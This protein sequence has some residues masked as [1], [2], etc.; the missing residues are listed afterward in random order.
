MI[1]VN[2]LWR[3]LSIRI[4]FLTSFFIV[5]ALVS[6]FNIYL[7]NNNYT[8]TDQFN[9]TMAN[10]YIINN[11]QVLVEDNRQSV[12]NYLRT[13]ED[14]EKNRYYD[15][16]AEIKQI[17]APL[18]NQ[19]D[20]LDIY[21][22]IKAIINSTN[23]YF[24]YFDQAIV[25]RESKKELYYVSYYAGSDIQK[26]TYSYIQELLYLSLSEGAKL[27]NELIEEIEVMRSV[28]FMLNI[29]AFIFAMFIGL[30]F[31][32]YLINPIKRLAEKSM[33][34]ANGDLNVELLPA[35]SKDEIGV[36]ANSFNI[37]SASI[38]KY[39]KDLEKKV[40][41]EKKLHI[42]EMEVIRMEQLVKEARFEAL[43]SQI[44][45]HFLFNTL[46]TISR[47][48]FFEDAQKTVKLIQSLSTL[49]RVR[50][51]H[52]QNFVSITEELNMIE[53]YIYLQKVRFGDRL[54]YIEKVSDNCKNIKVP[55]F[56]F[57]PIIENAIIH[58]VE[59]KVEGGTVRVKIYSKINQMGKEIIIIRITDT[60]I[61]MTRERINEIKEFKIENKKSIGVS[62]VYHRFMSVTKQKGRFTMRSHMGKGTFIEFRFEKGVIND[63]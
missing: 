41:I 3:H 33:R 24:D 61:G 46:N 40:E 19:Y 37:M 34:M 54:T 38:R 55:V 9:K 59:A 50:L 63:A 39:V 17:I 15:T 43:Q 25:D 2:E 6:L 62:N 57:Q 1:K 18:Y 52:N 36:L 44:N 7:N 42:E 32:N 60:G 26:Y 35:Q 23:S 29:G 53:E 4:K 21:F 45:P 11:L 5:L 27:N 22:I 10:Y 31:L 13:L 28:S 51:H 14:A 47:T 12:D 48:A 49:F 30:L 16:K 58:G 8:V 56:I 20:S